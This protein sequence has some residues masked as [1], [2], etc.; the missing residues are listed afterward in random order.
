MSSKSLCQVCTFGSLL[1]LSVALAT[2]NGPVPVGNNSTGGNGSSGG[3]GSPGSGPDNG[4]ATGTKIDLDPGATSTSVTTNTE[5]TDKDNCGVTTNEATKQADILLVLDRS[6]SMNYAMDSDAQCNTGGGGGRRNDAS[7]TTCQARWP[8]MK[9]ALAK[10]FQTSAGITWGLEL[11]S[12]PNKGNCVVSGDIQVPIAAGSTTA[13]NTQINNTS[14]GGYTPTRKGI[15]A[16][17]T[18]LQKLTGGE[19]KSILLATDGQPNCQGDSENTKDDVEETKAAIKAAADA[20]FKVYILGI[21]PE[22]STEAL[23]GF[24]EAGGT[25]V[26]DVSGPGKNYF[27]ALSAEELSKHFETIVSTVASCTFTLKSAPPVPNN[28]AVEF[29][30]DKSKRA[31]RSSTNG[32]EYTSG[33]NKVIQLYGSWCDGLMNGT[34]K[35]AKVLFG[36]GTNPI[37]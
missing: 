34:Y 33:D 25:A 19:G 1:S 22:A 14:P 8:T 28:I 36:C 31:P 20:G 26:K 30:G 13:I 15:A 11:Y 3:N 12:T 9:T 35:T 21:G 5:I 10:V 2:C 18:Y 7:A 4:Q 29:D 24:A 32:W 37:P 6:A 16:A 27:A 17:V 23:N